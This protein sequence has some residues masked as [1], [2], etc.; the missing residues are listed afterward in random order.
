MAASGSP[1]VE[2]SVTPHVIDCALMA[3]ETWLLELCEGTADLEP[4]LLKLLLES[5]SVMTT[6]VVASVCNAHPERGNVASLALLNSR[7]AIDMDRARTVREPPPSVL[8]NLP[9]SNP[10]QRFFNDERK[11]SSGLV[12]RPHDL[13]VLAWKLQFG[14]KGEQVWSDH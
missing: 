7:E 1:I 14:G 11:R 4:W 8:M 12:H 3:L 9:G 2:L 10:M 6:A 5:N 13:E